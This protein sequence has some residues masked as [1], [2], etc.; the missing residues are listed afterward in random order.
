MLCRRVP[1]FIFFEK[2]LR[3]N[4]KLNL[5]LKLRWVLKLRW[6]DKIYDQIFK[7]LKSRANNPVALM[8]EI[9]HIFTYQTHVGS[10]TPSRTRQQ[11]EVRPEICDADAQREAL[12][13]KVHD[14]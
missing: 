7:G 3:L 14:R 8:K 13:K 10:P 12:Q 1:T 6:W 5:K 11:S 4:L 9:D 2:D